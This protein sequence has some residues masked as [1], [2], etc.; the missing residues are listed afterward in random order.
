[1]WGKAQKV[2]LRRKK[3]II[4]AK[5]MIFMLKGLAF[6]KKESVF[7]RFEMIKQKFNGRGRGF[8]I[9][10]EYFEET[11]MDGVFEIKDWSYYDKINDFED[12]A[13]TNNGLESFHQMIKSQLR[14]IQ[15]SLPGLVD[16]LA[17]VEM[18]KKTD[19]DSEKI[20]G[21]PQF[22]RCWPSSRIFKELYIKETDPDI[23]Q[24]LF[25]E[26]QDPKNQ[27]PDKFEPSEPPLPIYNSPET[28]AS[29]QIQEIEMLFDE[30]LEEISLPRTDV[31]QMKMHK[32]MK[33][34]KAE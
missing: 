21:D 33:E 20:N 8:Q 11:W 30:F 9:F 16:I 31:G 24:T 7:R 1:L 28:P 13:I 5:E 18:L 10:L 27:T 15:P 32:M 23:S 19:Y 34:G 3:V 26:T 14:R 2:G 12:L 29:D 25:P 6:R 22:N 17:R 4:E